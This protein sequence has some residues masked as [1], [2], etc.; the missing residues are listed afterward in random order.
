MTTTTLD[1]STWSDR[2]ALAA[3]LMHEQGFDDTAITFYREHHGTG[4]NREYWAEFLEIADAILAVGFSRASVIDRTALTDALDTSEGW[5]E[6]GYTETSKAYW[7]GMRDTL[8]VVLGI[9]T[10]VPTVTGPG[11]DTAALMILGAQQRLTSETP[12]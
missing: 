2:T 9:T 5:S 1:L 11:T 8:R 4:S 6:H 7:T 12:Q 3:V 10:E